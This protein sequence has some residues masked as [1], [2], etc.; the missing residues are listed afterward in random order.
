MSETFVPSRTISDR[1]EL[2]RR[3]VNF[4]RGQELR[5]TPELRGKIEQV[6]VDTQNAFE[7]AAETALANMRDAWNS[8]AFTPVGRTKYYEW[9]HDL[10]LEMK[11]QGG[12][13]NYPLITLYADCLKQLTHGLVDVPTNLH[14]IIGLN[15]DAMAVVLHKRIVGPG[16]SVE[17]KVVEALRD[18]YAHFRL[19]APSGDKA[20]LAR[21]VATAVRKLDT[22]TEDGARQ[23]VLPPLAETGREWPL[24]T[25]LPA[26]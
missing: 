17:R 18:A 11:G 4:R 5:L 21:R 24:T 22:K 10:A 26:N 23:E 6:I 16:G 12:L 14:R 15:I 1:G 20:A 2:R 25:R 3:A 13:F 9:L 8:A 19:G 7:R